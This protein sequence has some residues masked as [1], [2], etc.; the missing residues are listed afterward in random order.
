[1]LKAFFQL[2]IFILNISVRDFMTHIS[3]TASLNKTVK[4]IAIWTGVAQSV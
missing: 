1:M 2:S 4:I 3:D